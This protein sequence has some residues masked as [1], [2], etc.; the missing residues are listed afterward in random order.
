MFLFLIGH[1][2]E[3]KAKRSLERLGLSYQDEDEL[4]EKGYDKTPDIK[5][6]IPF[7]YN[8][9]VI[10]WIGRSNYYLKISPLGG[11]YL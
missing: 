6:D 3:N 4:R 5:L 2:Y 1:D 9:Y 7:A 10:N 8:G 11:A